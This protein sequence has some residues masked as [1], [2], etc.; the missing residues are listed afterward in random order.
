MNFRASKASNWDTGDQS[1]C[2]IKSLLRVEE[3]EAQRGKGT[4]PKF[5][6]LK[7]IHSPTDH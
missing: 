3:A 5:L 1:Q 7:L 6:G 4:R 2:R